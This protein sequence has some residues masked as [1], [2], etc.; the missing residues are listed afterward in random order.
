MAFRNISAKNI[1]VIH[2]PNLN[3]LGKREPE[4]Y[5][6]TTLDD[7]N[8]KLSAISRAAE[9]RLDTFQSNNE[10]EL[11]NRV[12][13]AMDDETDFIII[14][15]AG[16]THTSIALRDALAATGVPF[17]E[18][19]LSNIYAREVFRHKSYFS[20]LAIGVISGLGAKGYELAL[21]FALTDR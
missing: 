18:I 5:G 4:I 6:K 17:I 15:P 7:I 16:L 13:Q 19:H 9:V 8:R 10:G 2:G 21:L 1:L 12:Q 3:L 20:D 14:N 11:I